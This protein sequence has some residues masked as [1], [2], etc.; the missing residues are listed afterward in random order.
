MQENPA[1]WERIGATIRAIRESR[2]LTLEKLAEL[3]DVTPQH[4][5]VVER[6]QVNVSVD[7]LIAIARPL[8]VEPSEFLIGAIPEEIPR[9]TP[10]DAE[11]AVIAQAL[12]LAVRYLRPVR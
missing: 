3:A 7:F 10:T 8:A 2:G 5:G 11:L 6:G 4:L 12:R 9:G 1:A